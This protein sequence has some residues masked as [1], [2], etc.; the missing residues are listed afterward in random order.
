MKKKI[1]FVKYVDSRKLIKSTTINLE[2]NK[3]EFN[4]YWI[5]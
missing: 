2:E 4:I 1:I 3:K 5:L